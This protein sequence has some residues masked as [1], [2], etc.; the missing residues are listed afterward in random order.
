MLL[1]DALSLAQAPINSEHRD[2]ILAADRGDPAAECDL[3]ILLLAS[4]RPEDAICWFERSAKQFYP[5]AMC[6]L[7]RCHLTGW[8]TARDRDVGLQWLTHAALK[9]HVIA[10]AWIGFFQSEQG[11]HLLNTFDDSALSQ[12]LDALERQLL[13]DLLNRSTSAQRNPAQG[14]ESV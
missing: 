2:L 8:G 5:E 13:L 11:Q 10:R 7:G 12:A 4:Q 3:G 14:P 6:W 1:E 9:G